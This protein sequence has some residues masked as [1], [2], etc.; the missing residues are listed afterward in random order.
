MALKETIL[1]YALDNAVKF[2]GKANPGAVI[3]KLLAEDP[4]LRKD[5][6][7]TAKQVN[8]VIKQVNNLSLKQQQ[9]KLKKYAKSLPKK[10]TKKRQPLPPLKNPKKVVM[11]FEPSPSGP[12]HLGH[13][14]A[15]ANTLRKIDTF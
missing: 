3:G 8:E 9:E 10:K 12:M 6:K 14:Y 13:A 1:K 5:M 4:A 11:R 7:A 15:I 2:N